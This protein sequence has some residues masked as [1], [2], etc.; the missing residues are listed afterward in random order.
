MTTDG[1][2][3][4]INDGHKMCIIMKLGICQMKFALTLHVNLFRSIHHNFRYGIIFK[5]GFNRT[6][7]KDFITDIRY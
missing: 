1:G 6:I 3:D 5:K 2:N 7:T 4:F